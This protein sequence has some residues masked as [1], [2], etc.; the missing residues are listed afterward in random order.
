MDVDQDYS[1]PSGKKA[2]VEINANSSSSS[3]SSSLA[4]KRP[5][6]EAMN[7]R[8]A[9]AFHGNA[10]HPEPRDGDFRCFTM[11]YEDHT[12]GNIVR[13]FLMRSPDVDGA[14][15]NIPHPANPEMKIWVS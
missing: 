13:S 11:R 5:L 2:R 12:M 7:E 14:G 15:Y 8:L 1:V 10:L 4:K 9:G 3:S 6:D